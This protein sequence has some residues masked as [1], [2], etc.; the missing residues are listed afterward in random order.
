VALSSLS[1]LVLVAGSS[2][3]AVS[4]TPDITQ[5]AAV[6]EAI[7]W[8]GQHSAPHDV[9]LSSYQVGNVIPARIGR[10]VVWGHWDET[11]FFDQKKSDV[12][13]FFDGG[14]PDAKRQD[15]LERYSVD[16]LFYGPTEQAMGDFDPMSVPYLKP[17]FSTAGVTVY[18]VEVGA[19]GQMESDNTSSNNLKT[20][21][22]RSSV[23]GRAI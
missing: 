12:T 2:L 18:Q 14:T 21:T 16:Y 22:G 23:L 10:R 13:V 9:I 4:G 3:A 7:S 20:T 5:P 6:E 8:L 17:S 1:N 15:I 11:A 19:P